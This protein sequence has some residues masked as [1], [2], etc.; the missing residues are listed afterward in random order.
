MAFPIYK[1]QLGDAEGIQIMSLVEHPAVESNFLA[2]EE[3]QP[4]QFSI[5]EEE[6]IV[7]GVALRADFPIY[8]YDRRGE[9][10]VVFDK[11]TIKQ[12]YEKFMIEGRVSEVNL[13]HSK[14]TGGVHLIQSFLKDTD[15][16]LNPKGFEE[17]ENGSWFCGY[18]IE[19]YEVW[20]RIKSGELKGF[21]VEGFFQLEENKKDELE[22]L[23][24][25]L[26]KEEI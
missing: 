15:N 3:Q 13:E 17:V 7:F 21:S 24:D 14:K 25:E 8:R 18:K 26:L 4:L 2:F 16:G 1:I 5:D 10:Y 20:N 12:L 22:E 23:I 6:R 9:Y 19:N 11:D